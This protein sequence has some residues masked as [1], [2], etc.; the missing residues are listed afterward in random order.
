MFQVQAKL[1]NSFEDI[2]LDDLLRHNIRRHARKG[3]LGEVF[4]T[5]GRLLEAGRMGFQ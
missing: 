5:D 4:A 3:Q 1:E 2:L